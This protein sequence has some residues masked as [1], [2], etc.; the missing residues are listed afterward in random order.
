[1]HLY[2]TAAV[3][4][5]ATAVSAQR[6]ADTPICDYYTEALLKDNTADNQATILTLIVN[7]VVIGN[8]TVP[9]VGVKVPG[10]LSPGQYMGQDVNLLPYFNGELASSN[11]GGSSGV[12]INFLDD[13]GAEP[14]MSNKPA[15]T[16][17][18]NQ[19]FLLTHLY[20]FFGSLLGCSK[21][22]M[23]GFEAYMG[24][25]SMYEVHRFMGLNSAETG[26][27]INQVALAAA[28]FGVAQ[29]DISAVGKAL[30]SLFDVRCAPPMTAIKA[31]GPQLQSICI[32]E[33]C[34]LA[35]NATCGSYEPVLE[36]ASADQSSSAAAS[37]TPCPEGS[38]SAA[39]STG[40]V[41]PMGTGAT[42]GTSSMNISSPTMIPTAG[43]ATKG[44]GI[45]AAAAGAAA[46]LL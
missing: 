35:P 18:S 27:F 40:A 20:Q 43:A 13:G 44:F 9:N 37:S 23:P 16:N 3:M 7:T 24:H 34:L 12:A 5:A 30:T 39:T 36:P 6:P 29:D 19:Y 11:R 33:D 38:S 8:Y 32:T 42:N 46:L 15:N 10:I 2:Q 22:G 14:L 41:Y 28:S 45:A 1:M 4:A 25:A 21:Q 26:Y 17:T 31:Q